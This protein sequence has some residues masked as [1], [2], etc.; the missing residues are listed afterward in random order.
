MSGNQRW[1]ER[2]DSY[3]PAGETIQASAFDV[4]AISSDN[5]ARAF[6]QAHHYSGTYPAARFRFGLYH[7]GELAGVAV[8]SHPCNDAVLTNVFDAPTSAAVE[9]GR[10]V[11]LD[12]VPGNGETWFLARCFEQLR[13]LGIRGVVS[14]SDPIPRASLDGRRIFPGHIGT[15]Y[16][17]HNARYLGRSSAVPLRLLPDGQVLSKR[18]I[19]KIRAGERGWRYAAELLERFGASPAPVEDLEARGAWLVEQLAQLTRLVR[20]PGNHR[21]AWALDRRTRIRLESLPFPKASACV[22]QLTHGRRAA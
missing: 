10:F 14:F 8:F 19:S 18:A 2:R 13:P 16:Q 3:R 11:L 1:R 4:T 5:V 12:E 15:I 20:H 17:A 9:L 22:P 6:V 7:R 21:Y